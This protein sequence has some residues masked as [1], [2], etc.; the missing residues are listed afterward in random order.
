MKKLLF[1]ALLLGAGMFLSSANAQISKNPN[2]FLGNITT[3]NSVN[4]SGYEFANMWNQ[5]TAE[6]ESKWQSIEGSKRGTFNWWGSDNAFNY[7]KNHNI[8]FKFHT[9]IWGSQYPTWMDN[10]STE[11]QYAAIVEWMDAVK[12]HYPDL[13]MIDVVN[14]AIDGHAPAPYKEALGGDG[15]TGYDW[16]VKAF[17]MAHERWPNAILIYNDYNTF[18]WQKDQYKSIVTTLINAG[19]P[20]DAYGCQS[21]GLEDTSIGI[22]TAAMEELQSAFQIPMYCTEYDCNIADDNQQKQRFQEQFQYMWERPYVAGITLWGYIYGSTWR[23]NTGLIKNGTERPALTWLRNY[24]ETSAAKAATGPFEKGFVKEASVYVEPSTTNGFVG[25]E[26][27]VLVKARL[28]T[29]TISNVKLYANNNLIA[30]MTEAP[31]KAQFTPTQTG[32]VTLKAVVTATDGTVYERPGGFQVYQN[33][34]PF[35]GV[36][37]LPGTLEAE[38]FDVCAE[39]VSY[40][41]TDNV[42]EGGTNYRSDGGGVDIV[43]GNGGYAIGYTAA[44]EWLEYTVD[45]KQAGEY[46]YEA[47]ASSGSNNSAFSIGLS[48]TASITPLTDRIV[49]PNG[50]NWDDYTVLSGDLKQPLQKGQQIIRLNILAPYCNIDKIVFKFKGSTAIDAISTD[51]PATYDL[52]TPAG[53]YLGRIN[54]ASANDVMAKLS[55]QTVHRGIVILRNL[56]TGKSVKV[57]VK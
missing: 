45:V 8:P 26:M 33:R 10:L 24:M 39:G 47:Y 20:I 46:S 40:H 7:A 1:S 12:A 9:L 19:A 6:N 15:K 27:S 41:D 50:G 2:K 23:D 43:T 3:N 4:P 36:I 18:R 31:Y 32:K 44:G 29:K 17:E 56:N 54:G 55:G 57:T 13:P 21:H 28:R 52:F 34:S 16:I 11:Q 14:E 53:T 22:F 49:V 42:N 37:S 35:N 5:I 48:N 30:T 51:S 38:N 25:Y